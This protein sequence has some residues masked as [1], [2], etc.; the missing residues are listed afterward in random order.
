MIKLSSAVVT[1]VGKVR[2]NNEDNYFINGRYKE[3]VDK[4][5]DLFTDDNERQVYAF[6][7][8]DGM[9]GEAYGEI[10]SR[11]AAKSLNKFDAKKYDENIY[12]YF[13]YANKLICDEIEKNDGARV[14]TTVALLYIKNNSAYCYN[15]G[16]SRIYRIRND[17]IEQLTKDH[18][19]AQ[20][21]VDM[22]LL[23]REDMN[24]HKGKHRLTQHLGI[25][26]EELLIQAYE[27]GKMNIEKDDVYVLCSDGLTDMLDDSDILAVTRTCK[28]AE[29]ISR[30]L[31][32]K[33]LENGGKDNVTVVTVVI[34]DITEERKKT[35][36][37]RIIDK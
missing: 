26:P 3:D 15:I 1:D 2:G 35:I 31:A 27:T 14:G 22:G 11:I 9:G 4:L 12:E 10:A 20:S 18:T 21:M 25:F 16:D 8:C 32:D 19:Q 37:S 29:E 30:S 5:R 13:E 36:W 28:D 6:A 24:N 23:R 7:V 17:D 34:N 33:A